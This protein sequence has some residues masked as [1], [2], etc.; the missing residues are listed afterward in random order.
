MLIKCPE[1]ELQVSDK[2]LICP[3]CGY[4]L[5]Q[6]VAKRAI[7]SDRKKRKSLPN[8][9]GQISEIK[10]MNLRKPFRAMVTV[11]TKENGRPIVK[12]LKPE[13]YFETY[14][15]AYEALVKYNMNPYDL[16]S[17]ITVK[18]LYEKWFEEYKSKLSSNTSTRTITSA[19]A[20]C[21]QIYD[22]R[23][24]DIRA[25]HIK[26]V[27]DEA[28]SANI[29]SRIK[30]LFNLMLDYAVE[31]EIVEKNYAR[32]FSVADAILKE[33]AE[34]KNPHM[35]FSKD[36]LKILWK[37]I[38]IPFV[39]VVLIQCYGGW[40]PQE[41]GLIELDNVDLEQNIIIGG[42][43]TE[44]GTNR[45]V[46]IHSA[47]RPFIEKYHKE[48]TELGSKYLINSVGTTHSDSTMFTYDKYRHRFE[49]I[50]EVLGLNK[51]HRCH[52]GRKTFVTLAKESGVDEYAIKMMVGHK[53]S[54]ITEAVYTDRDDEWL[55]TELAKI[56]IPC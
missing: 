30:S 42:M 23:A 41:L 26:G 4:P 38:N 22:M 13:A 7:R 24:M 47:I 50:I 52:D 27:M 56:K 34:V 25:R 31:Y 36:E 44:A 33:I 37:N 5:D 28:T 29:K 8:G 12:M 11:G 19:W 17:S 9:F 2:A 49:N 14:N 53:I 35:T 1:C 45:R 3:H 16:D 55:K 48:A 18:E 40:R 10:N 6:R 43:K 15:D 32:T 39:D 54:D 51:D 21:T 46:P 20:H